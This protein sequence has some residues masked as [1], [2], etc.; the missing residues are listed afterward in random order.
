M[1][2][3]FSKPTDL[4]KALVLPASAN[5]EN[6]SKQEKRLTI[7]DFSS[8]DTGTLGGWSFNADITAVPEPSNIALLGFVA[9][10]VG[11]YRLRRKRS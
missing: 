2:L 7:T 6:V 3:L 1:T 8:P 11:F 10:T 9:S 4:D 5:L